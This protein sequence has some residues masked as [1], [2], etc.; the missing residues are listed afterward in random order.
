[1]IDANIRVRFATY[2][3]N[4]SALYSMIMNLDHIVYGHFS[5]DLRI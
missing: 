2:S 5:V 4:F 1:M 3:M